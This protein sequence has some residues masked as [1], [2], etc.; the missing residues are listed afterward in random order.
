[1]DNMWTVEVQMKGWEERKEIV[2]KFEDSKDYRSRKLNI[3]VS[4]RTILRVLYVIRVAKSNKYSLL[5]QM[6]SKILNKQLSVLFERRIT[7]EIAK[8]FKI[9]QIAHLWK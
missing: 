9:I 5:L 8:I 6:N 2:R 4:T 3:W 1:M 7:L